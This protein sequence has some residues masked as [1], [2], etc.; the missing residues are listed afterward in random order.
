MDM[1]AST[2]TETLHPFD[3][4]PDVW[5]SVKHEL[6]AGEDRELMFSALVRTSRPIKGD[7]QLGD[8][9]GYSVDTD[10]AAFTKATLYLV[11]WNVPGPSGKPIDISSKAAKVSGLKALKPERFTLIERA[12]DVFLDDL[13]K[14]KRPSQSSGSS[15]PKEP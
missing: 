10:R 12:I 6:N 3:D 13:A 9:I 4:A 11:D 7:G 2:E 8:E 1:T 15:A 14:K 5:I